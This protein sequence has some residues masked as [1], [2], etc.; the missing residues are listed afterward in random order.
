MSKL[1]EVLIKNGSDSFGKAVIKSFEDLGIGILSKADFEAYL[2]HQL[3]LVTDS[4]KVRNNFDWQ[5]LLKITAPKLRTLQN[6]RSARYLNL[7]LDNKENWILL[8][9]ELENCNIE[10]EDLQKG[11]IKFYVNDAH[12]HDF[13]NHFVV[14]K[15]SSID[16]SLNQNQVIVKFHV[17][18]E[19]LETIEVKAEELNFIK[20]NKTNLLT[21][22]RK[23]KA[24]KK[25]NREIESISN[26]WSDFKEKIKDETF[27]KIAEDTVCEIVHNGITYIRKRIGI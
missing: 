17:F 19:L 27:E 21:T 1:S 22:L 8:F 12:V 15:R 20:S 5:R 10:I 13:I 3:T 24:V 18:L 16:K 4:S 23:D 9:K 25:L 6:T 14:M 7:N 2:F 11:T 26:L